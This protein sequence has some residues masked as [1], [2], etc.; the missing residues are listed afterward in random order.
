MAKPR[1][2][3]DDLD[4]FLS[5]DRSPDACMQLSDLDG[6]LTAVAVGPDE[7]SMEEWLPVIWGGTKP[8][9]QDASEGRQVIA[10]IKARYDDIVTGLTRQPPVVRPVFW[11]RDGEPIVADWAEGFMDGVRLR[12]GEWSRLIASQDNTI[13]IPL[14]VNWMDDD[15][16]PII[17]VDD[18]VRERINAEAPELIP[19]TV[20]AIYGYWRSRAESASPVAKLH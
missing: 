12:L 9:F 7:I 4:S 17:H 10:A 20:I 8:K 2:D 1:F 14:A 6:F 16:Q 15:D 11:M 18:D 5:S 13:L 19:A 3:L